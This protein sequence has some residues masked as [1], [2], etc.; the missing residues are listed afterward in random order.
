MLCS[1]DITGRIALFQRK[2]ESRGS[3]G[4][5]GEIRGTGGDHSQNVRY[6]RR[7]KKKKKKCCLTL[8]SKATEA[9]IHENL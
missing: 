5:R 7:I 8:G 1:V 6:D 4:R 9:I 3:G 2:T